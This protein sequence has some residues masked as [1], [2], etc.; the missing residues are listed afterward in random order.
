MNARVALE[1]LH[2]SHSCLLRGSFEHVKSYALAIQSRQ[3]LQ[4]T[5]QLLVRSFTNG[6]YTGKCRRNWNPPA[7]PGVLSV[8]SIFGISQAC[9]VQFRS[10]AAADVTGGG[11]NLKAEG[12]SADLPSLS[13]WRASL[14]SFPLFRK[15]AGAF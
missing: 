13:R 1:L 14:P 12:I 2:C 8:P 9:Q 15:I 3:G 11:S 7:W 10:D 6:M 5:S 4:S